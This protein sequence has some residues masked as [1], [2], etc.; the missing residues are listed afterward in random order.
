MPTPKKPRKPAAGTP[1]N[2]LPSVP[3][4][5]IDQFLADG[6]HLSS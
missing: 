5:L 4:E 3:K 1:E 2:P 6:C